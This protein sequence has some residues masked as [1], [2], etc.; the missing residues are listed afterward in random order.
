MTPELNREY[1]AKGW[2][3]IDPRSRDYCYQPCAN[4]L[5][6]CGIHPDEINFLTVANFA[7]PD[8][9]S[10]RHLFERAKA[11]CA[12]SGDEAEDL[13]VDLQQDDECCEDFCMSRQMLARLGALAAFYDNTNPKAGAPEHG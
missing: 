12:V 9:D 6:V 4:G 11:E 8:A 13:V 3:S 10:A 2:P 1:A 5:H 7:T